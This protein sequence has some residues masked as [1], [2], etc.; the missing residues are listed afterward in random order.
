[1]NERMPG[2]LQRGH[3]REA[4]GLRGG[5]GCGEHGTERLNTG[6]HCF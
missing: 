3:S 2:T 1:M 6:P 5:A 4:A